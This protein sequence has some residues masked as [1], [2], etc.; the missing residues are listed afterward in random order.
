MEPVFMILGQSAG[1]AAALALDADVAVQDVPYA[2]LRARLLA[3]KQ[4]LGA[5]TA[6][7]D[8]EGTVV[9]DSDATLT[10]AWTTAAATKPFVGGGYQHDANAAKG[11]KARFV[12]TLPKAGHY[13]VRLA[14][15]VNANRATN[16]PVTVEHSAGTAN[17]VVN[18]QTPPTADGVFA[19]VGEYDF[20]TGAAVEIST[21]GTNGYVII[22]AVQFVAK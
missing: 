6:P 7:G 9:D 20:G 18:Q 21:A 15:T 14:Y 17:V 16:V 22:D 13:E 11:K 12:A 8:F 2:D 10:G 4:V 5:G 1:T 19:V 3:D